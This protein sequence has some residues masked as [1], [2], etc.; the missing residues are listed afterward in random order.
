MASNT[1]ETQT[2][3]V[4]VRLARAGDQVALR[5]G[6]Q[7]EWDELQKRFGTLSLGRLTDGGTLLALTAEDESGQIVGFLGLDDYPPL[8]DGKDKGNLQSRLLPDNWDK[9]WDEDYDKSIYSVM[10]T[11]WISFLWTSGKETAK[12]LLEEAFRR[13][14]V[15]GILT[16]VPKDATNAACLNE[17]FRPMDMNPEIDEDSVSH[18]AHVC[19]I[20]GLAGAVKIRK[21][22]V[23]DYD[24]LIKLFDGGSHIVKQKKDYLLAEILENQTKTNQSLVASL[25]GRA[26]GLMCLATELEHSELEDQFSLASVNYFRSQ[27]TLDEMRKNKRERIEQRLTKEAVKAEKE[28]RRKIRDENRRRKLQLMFDVVSQAN[29]PVQWTKDLVTEYKQ[30]TVPKPETQAEEV[31]ATAAKSKKRRSKKRN[32][33]EQEYKARLQEIKAEVEVWFNEELVDDLKPPE[34]PTPEPEPKKGLMARGTQRLVGRKAAAAAMKEKEDSEE[35]SFK[36]EFKQYRFEEVIEKSCTTVKEV[37]D[38]FAS[39]LESRRLTELEKQA[40]A[41]ETTAEED[42]PPPRYSIFLSL[43]SLELA[44]SL[45]M[46]S[47]GSP[48]NSRCLQ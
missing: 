8:P 31:G 28:R 6:C 5:L 18:R 35:E 14:C 34:P 48:R 46:P 36:F 16:L 24:D 4:T 2:S 29:D 39:V 37:L 3:K 9:W 10:N 44:R 13:S 27:N 32:G 25:N 11:L 21:A 17:W 7:V 30:S 40:T 45:T 12:A 20:H 15:E 42:L 1:N 33:P 38:F 26:M 41:D 43:F 47:Q 22:K 19:P 23:Q